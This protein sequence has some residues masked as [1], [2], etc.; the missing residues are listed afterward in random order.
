MKKLLL[1]IWGKLGLSRG[2]QLFVMR[3]LHDQFLIG[4]T[5][6]I[7]NKKNQ[8]LLFNHSYRDGDRW[9]LPG[10]Y[11][12]SREH[13]HEALE[14]EVLEESGYVVY[15]EEELKTRTDRKSARLDV[16]CVGT[17]MGGEFTPSEEIIEAGFFSFDELPRLRRDQ[18]FFIQRALQNRT[19][20]TIEKK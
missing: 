20:A 6:I 14:R 16:V 15:V 9:S 7:F 18:V 10:G 11:I 8:V 3:R 17:F 4:V 2:M 12:Q 19:N 5:G 1:T 13:P